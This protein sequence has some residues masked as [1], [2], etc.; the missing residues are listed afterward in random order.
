MNINIVS[1]DIWFL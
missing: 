1:S